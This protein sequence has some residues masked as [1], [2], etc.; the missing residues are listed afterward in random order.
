MRSFRSAWFQQ[1][2]WLEYSVLLNAIF[3]FACR[4]F[5]TRV[6]EPSYTLGGFQNWKKAH[7]CDGGLPQHAKC[8]YYM[9]AVLAWAEYEKLKASGRQVFLT[10]C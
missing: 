8:E 10:A 7:F 4:H 3:C 9:N 6:G 5:G 2:A 1:Y